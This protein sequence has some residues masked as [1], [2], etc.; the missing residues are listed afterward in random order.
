VKQQDCSYT[1]PAPA[2]YVAG[3]SENFPSLEPLYYASGMRKSGSGFIQ[4]PF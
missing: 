2:H 3:R 1:H 4:I